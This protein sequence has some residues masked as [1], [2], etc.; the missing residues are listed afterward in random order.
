MENNKKDNN[1]SWIL[2]SLA[3]SLLITYLNFI[4]V[5]R[6]SILGFISEA[7]ILFLLLIIIMNLQIRSNLDNSFIK[8]SQRYIKTLET[9]LQLLAEVMQLKHE[10]K[11]DDEVYLAIIH[12]TKNNKYSNSVINEDIKKD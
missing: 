4:L 6:G 3:F 5:M 9:E 10:N 7:V 8:A 12:K 11:I 1:T 2:L